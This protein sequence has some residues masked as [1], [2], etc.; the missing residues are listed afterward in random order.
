M[1]AWLGTHQ[2]ANM[3][4]RGRCSPV[5]LL[6]AALLELLL[7]TKKLCLALLLLLPPLRASHPHAWL[8]LPMIQLGLW[9]TA[10][11]GLRLTLQ[12]NLLWSVQGC[13]AS[14]ARHS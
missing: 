11:H 4:F 6:F 8:K 14:M 9:P 13:V 3:F 12:T 2:C 5:I 1:R 7:G 10:I